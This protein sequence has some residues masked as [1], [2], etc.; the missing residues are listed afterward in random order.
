[1]Y[2]VAGTRH[3]DLYACAVDI[4]LNDADK[5]WCLVQMCN[6]LKIPYTCMYALSD[7]IL[8]KITQ[9]EMPSFYS[10]GLSPFMVGANIEASSSMSTKTEALKEMVHVAFKSQFQAVVPILHTSA[11]VYRQQGK[12]EQALEDLNRVLDIKPDDVPALK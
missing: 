9:L 5:F 8:A 4:Y 3:S 2:V 6:P 11:D 10:Q 7:P 1:M 12:Y